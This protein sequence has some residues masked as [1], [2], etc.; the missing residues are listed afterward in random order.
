MLKGAMHL[1]SIYSDG[2]FTLAEIRELFLAEGCSFACLTD[3]AE[4]FDERSIQN[5]L[6]ECKSLSDDKFLLVPGLEYRCERE[7]HILGYGAT[8]LAQTKDPQGVIRHIDAQGAISVIAHPKNDSFS[9]LESFATLPLGIETWNT[10]YDGRYAPRPA[11]FALLR[12][13][14]ER[15]PE[16][17]AFYG[18]DLH[19]KKQFRGM[20]VEVD[21]AEAR[22]ETILGALAEGKYSARKDP[23]SLPASGVLSEELLTQFGHD[24]G[25][26]QRVWRLLKTG[27]QTLARL[28]IRVPESIKAQLRRIF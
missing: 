9:W 25:R 22:I 26:S 16:M 2:E 23:Y 27:K 1:H 11:T 4:F 13:L 3:H 6:A 10:K 17:R 24:H 15:C 21:C 20:L 5:Y 8:G 18:Q 19:W 7:M 14:Q 12:R 28:G